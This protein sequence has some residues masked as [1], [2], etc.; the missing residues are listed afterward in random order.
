MEPPEYSP[1]VD[2][3]VKWCKPFGNISVSSFIKLSLA[4]NPA[5]PLLG[6]YLRKMKACVH[7]K[8][9]RRT[10]T[11]A[12][13]LEDWWKCTQVFT[14]RRLDKHSVVCLYTGLWLR[15]KEKQITIITW[16]NLKIIMLTTRSLT[17]MSKYHVICLNGH[18]V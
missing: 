5:I 11:A 13:L 9:L 14:N 8:D 12:L 1:I 15:N 18:E 4:C 17:Q 2:E 10:C 7:Q 3:N 16:I 6:I